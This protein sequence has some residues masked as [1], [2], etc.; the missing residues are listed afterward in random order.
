MSTA[1]P[2]DKPL[3]IVRRAELTKIGKKEV[4][5]KGFRIDLMEQHLHGHLKQMSNKWCTVDCLARCMLGRTSETNR[6]AIRKR[7]GW[8]FKALLE[9]Y[10]LFLVIDYDPVPSK[11]RKI[12]AVKL[13]ESGMGAEGQYALGQ[14]Q[15]MAARQKMSEE[16]RQH[17]LT[18]IGTTDANP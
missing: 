7:I 16:M 3:K 2:A 13:Y 5:T 14:L 8:A 1:D 9:R 4:S 6:V 15:R 11:H 18:I 17:A 12:K 10:N